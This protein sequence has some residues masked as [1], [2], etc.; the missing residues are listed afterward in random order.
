MRVE[1]TIAI[2]GCLQGYPKTSSKLEVK[3]FLGNCDS[4]CGV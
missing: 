4:V 1:A 2:I 3:Y